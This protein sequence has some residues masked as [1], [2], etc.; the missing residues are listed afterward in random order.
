VIGAGVLANERVVLQRTGDGELSL[1]GWWLSDGKG[2]DYHFPQLTLFK[3]GTINL[4]TRIGQDT[5]V[6]LFWN[7][8]SPMWSS[9]KIISIYDAQNNLRATYTVP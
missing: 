6:D 5:V 2:N 8:T 4:N 9:G 1:S 7:L 3:G